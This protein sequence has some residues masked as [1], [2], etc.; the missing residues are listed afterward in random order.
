MPKAKQAVAA[1]P[2]TRSKSPHVDE[3]SESP[4]SSLSL[5]KKSGKK[6]SHPRSTLP[7]RDDQNVNNTDDHSVDQQVPVS[8]KSKT[9]AA[10]ETSPLAPYCI[11]QMEMSDID[12]VFNLGLA[13]FTSKEFPNMYRLW[14]DFSVVENFASS[15]EFCYVAKIESTGE[16]VAFLLGMTLTKYSVG[17]RGYIQWVCVVPQYRRHHIATELISRFVAVAKD[18]KVSMLLADTPASNV[19]A[20]N[21]F[22]KTGLADKTDHVYLTRRLKP[23]EGKR[24]KVSDDGEFHFSYTAKKKHITVRNMEIKDLNSVYDLGNIIFTSN[25]SNIWN[26]WDEDTVMHNYI[27]DPEFCIVATAKIGKEAEKVVGFAFG[28]TI[29]KPKS[30]WKY[31][32]LIWTGCDPNYQGLGLASQLYNTMVELFAIEKVRMLMIDTQVNNEAAI[33]FFRKLG[34]GHDEKHVYL[35]NKPMEEG[36][37]DTMDHHKL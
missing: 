15:R 7:T 18:Q 12:S 37:H 13:I 26:F 19:P 30:S 8:K 6:K 16:I 2:A 24:N 9:S 3:F 32:Y 5:R 11:R 28:T 27:N 34:F 17:T 36:G 20:I 33:K 23:S 14:D 29:E 31:G 25:H 21:M 4:V 10:K 22:Q 1:V 35:C